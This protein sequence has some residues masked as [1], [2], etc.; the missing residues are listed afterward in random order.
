MKKNWKSYK[1]FLVKKV[2]RSDLDP[3]QL[4]RIWI[5]P[6]QKV[7]SPYPAI[8]VGRGAKEVG[9]MVG[10]RKYEGKMEERGEVVR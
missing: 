2:K 10:E 8:C 6:G 1:N 3:V 9:K 4:F 5:R 7:H